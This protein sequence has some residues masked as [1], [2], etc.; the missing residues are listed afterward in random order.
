[1]SSTVVQQVIVRMLFDHNFMHY[2]YEQ[3]HLALQ[4]VALNRDEIDSIL[5][6]DQRRWSI[7][8][9]RKDRALEGILLYTPVSVALWI[10]VGGH[11]S[12]LL[13]FF[14]S[15][16]FHQAIHNRDW[17]AQAFLQW[18]SNTPPQSLTQI[19]TFKSF[20]SQNFSKISSKKDVS[21][22]QK[23]KKQKVKNK[24]QKKSQAKQ[25][26]RQSSEQLHKLY[27]WQ[28]CQA[29]IK[30]EVACIPIHNQVKVAVHSDSSFITQEMMQQVTAVIYDSSIILPQLISCESSPHMTLLSVEQHALKIYQ[31]IKSFLQT[32]EH[33]S[34]VTASLYGLPQLSI[35]WS[36]TQ[37]M[38]TLLLEN[39]EQGI[40][41]SEI[42]NGLSQLLT[43]C[44]AV[45]TNKHSDTLIALIKCLYKA[46]LDMTQAQDCLNGLIEDGLIKLI[47]FS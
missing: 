15:S 10:E 25:S 39:S 21:K 9:K 18:L 34:I 6:V 4:G 44:S 24:K 27:L 5:A 7:D 11:V 41:M 38:V 3:P 33:N 23:V 37:N 17:L 46:G 40:C 26:I 42:P 28:C 14:E 8:Q 20:S 1:M 35:Q 32:Q 12:D 29:M 36:R 47:V 19:K 2:V 45:H 13:L 31:K 43:L 22:K 16:Y 30:I